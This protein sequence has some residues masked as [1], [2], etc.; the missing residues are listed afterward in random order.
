M[1]PARELIPDVL[2]TAGRAMTRSEIA[3]RIGVDK[4]YVSGLLKTMEGK[5]VVRAT[6]PGGKPGWTVAA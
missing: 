6:T 2:R 1:R 5:T 4:T 3:D